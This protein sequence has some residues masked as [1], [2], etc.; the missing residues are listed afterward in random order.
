[1]KIFLFG[2]GVSRKDFDIDT[3]RGEGLLV[4]CNWAYK[5]YPFNI[6]CSADK[7]VSSKI[8]NNWDGDW[9]RRDHPTLRDNVYLNSHDNLICT[10]PVLSHGLGWNTGRAAIYALYKLYNPTKIYLLGFDLGGD[11][12]YVTIPANRPPHYEK[13]WNYLFGLVPCVRVG[14]KDDMTPLLTCEHLTYEEFS[15]VLDKSVD[16]RYRST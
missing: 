9:I 6:I 4:G 14:P 11:N 13:C 7:E 12:L 1:M 8:K 3:L 10:L 2:N 15:K 16:S 5:D